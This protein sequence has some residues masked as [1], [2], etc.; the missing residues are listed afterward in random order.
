MVVMVGMV[1]M[2]MMVMVVMMVAGG[3][4]EMG[5]E[6]VLGRAILI[7]KKNNVKFYFRLFLLT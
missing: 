5:R 7:L 1:V 2:V 3:G 6:E 4:W